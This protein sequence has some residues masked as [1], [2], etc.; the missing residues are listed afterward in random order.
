MTIE[1]VTQNKRELLP[2]LLLGDEQESQIEKYLTR[3]DL[4]VLYDDGP[5]KLPVAAIAVTDEGD[6]VIEIQNL[7]TDPRYRRR[8]HA[9]R[10]VNYVAERYG[11]KHRKLILGTGEAPSILRFYQNLGFRITHRIPDYFTAHYDH[12]MVEEGILLKDKVYLERE[13]P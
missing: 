4:F 13:I 9:S 7:A 8:G 1:R 10:L 6:G 11:R 3:G 5:D 2:L 12:P